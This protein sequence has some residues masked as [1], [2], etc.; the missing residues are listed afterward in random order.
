MPDEA[1]RD[2]VTVD[3]LRAPEAS[4]V[5]EAEY[6]RFGELLE[7]LAPADW[8]RPT[9]CGPWDVRLLVAHVLGATEANASPREMVRQLRRGRRGV[10]VEVDPVSAV[11][12]SQRRALEPATLRQRYARAVPAAVAWRS[13]WSRLAGAVPMRVGAP[14]HETW[15]LRYLMDVVYTRDVWMHRV[16]VCR[17]IDREPVLTPPHDGWIVADVVA[18]WS[19]RHGR[20][21]ALTLEGPAGGRFVS[22]AGGTQLTADAVEFCRVLSGRGRGAGLLATSVPF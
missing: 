16:D 21:F 19:G 7:S 18:D 4:A 15:R 8:S 14:V 6:R 13:R 3:R 2:V 17:A 1:Q 20:P 11:Q 12:V 9:E 5:A 10:A 22:G